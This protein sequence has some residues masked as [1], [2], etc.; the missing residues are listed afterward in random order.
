MDDLALH[1]AKLMT[2]ACGTGSLDGPSRLSGGA[3]METW[4]FDW[5]G[6]GYVLRRAPSA[7]FMAGKDLTLADEAA[8]IEVAREAGVKVPSVV[9]VLGQEDGLGTG[10]VMVKIEAEVEPAKI[11]AAI[12]SNLIDQLG[13]ELAKIHALPR[14]LAPQTV[15]LL[16]AAAAVA[17]F[18]ARFLA[19]GGDRPAIALA[20]RWCEDH[21]PAPVEPVLLHGD[22]RMGNVMVDKTGLVAVL[23]WELA[24]LGD[25]HLDLAYGC[26]PV[27]RF[28][29]LDKPAF[30]IASLD[31]YFSAY[32]AG[33]GRKVDR[34]RFRFWL[35]YCTLW[36]MIG[37][38]D[39][40]QAWRTGA[41]RTVE[42]V[43]I[44]RR[45][46]EQELDLLLLL[47]DEA[48]DAEQARPMPASLPLAPPAIGEPSTREIVE[49]V[50]EWLTNTVKAHAKGHEKFEVAVAI[51]A[52]GIVIRDLETGIRATDEEFARALM[53]GE[54][55]LSQPGLLA[56]LRR[57]VLDKCAVDSPKYAPLARAR[58]KWAA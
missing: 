40:G 23:D 45:V 41:D 36:W 30:G 2:R 11:M 21:L 26:L 31:A 24:R 18:K 29:A 43:V 54:T 44:A 17:D 19:Y 13:A 22:Y 46:A 16:D 32:E 15:P 5:N 34:E 37:C 12:P 39:M 50:R 38:L 9:V 49:A 42:R 57:R 28:G 4:A 56:A 3:N 55:S 8:L 1:I 6:K 10:Y 47:D 48:P 33:G 27:W 20:I 58:A 14:N 52:L 25:P 51:N 35:V 7:A 53:T